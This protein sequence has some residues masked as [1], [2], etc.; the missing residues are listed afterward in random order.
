MI[1]RTKGRADIRWLS[2]DVPGLGPMG[3]LRTALAHLKQPVLL[4]G[5]DMPHSDRFS[6]AI[7]ESMRPESCTNLWTPTI[8]RG[9]SASA[10]KERQL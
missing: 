4:V 8:E 2:D 5:C 1:G 9:N 3:G 7:R 10:R 6:A